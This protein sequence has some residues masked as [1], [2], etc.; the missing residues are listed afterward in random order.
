VQKSSPTPRFS[1]VEIDLP[2][3]NAPPNDLLPLPCWLAAADLQSAISVA[4]RGTLFSQLGVQIRCMIETNSL[5]PYRRNSR[6]NAWFHAWF[7][8]LFVFRA[9]AINDFPA[10]SLRAGKH[11]QWTWRR[12]SDLP[13][14]NLNSGSGV[15]TSGG[16][17]IGL[18][19]GRASL[20][21][22]ILGSEA[23]SEKL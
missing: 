4:Q 3:C 2:P 7:C 21:P 20:A 15:S 11:G 19:F 12:G 23:R 14:V 22:R 8:C 9:A 10:H 16:L 1:K 5:L 6:G 18:F 17:P 13:V